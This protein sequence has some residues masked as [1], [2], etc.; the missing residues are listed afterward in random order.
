[1][2]SLIWGIFGGL[3]CVNFAAFAIFGL[4]KQKAKKKAWRIPEKTL[5]ALSACF[6]AVGAL[7]GMRVFHHKTRK[8]AFSVGV[9]VMLVVQCAVV[10][11]LAWRFL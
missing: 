7:C 3:I 4:D 8:K 9:P 1:M 2:H 11:Y 6:G 10:I 5:L